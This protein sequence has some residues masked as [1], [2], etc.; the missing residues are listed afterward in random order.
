MACE[1]SLAAGS[2]NHR[3]K[4][5]NHLRLPRA[6][7]GFLELLRHGPHDY[8]SNDDLASRGGSYGSPADNL[9]RPERWSW[10]FISFNPYTN[11]A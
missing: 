3:S 7:E 11:G 1:T 2:S 8:M 4:Y 6:A 10:V 5:D 9:E